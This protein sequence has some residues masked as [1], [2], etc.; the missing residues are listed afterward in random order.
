MFDRANLV[1]PLLVLPIIL[2]LA[3]CAPAS[4]DAAAPAPSVT[5]TPNT[6]LPDAGEFPVMTPVPEP[7]EDSNILTLE[8]AYR[9]CMDASAQNQIEFRDGPSVT[10]E[11]RT[12]EDYGN[13]SFADSKVIDREDRYFFVYSD[14]FDHSGSAD[15]AEAGASYCLVGGTVSEPIWQ[16]YGMVEREYGK[17]LDPYA[18]FSK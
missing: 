14:L 18:P 1:R 6:L 9:L 12:R 13:A 7:G 5:A 2:M 11:P 3:G 16:T 15:V 17:T 8:S 10:G 4:S